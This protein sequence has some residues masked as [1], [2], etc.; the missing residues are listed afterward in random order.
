MQL[1]VNHQ[2]RTKGDVTYMDATADESQAEVFSD[3][4][5]LVTR[6]HAPPGLMFSGEIDTTNAWAVSRS[7]ADAF[8]VHGDAH[9]DL[10]HLIFCDISGI[11]ALVEAAE[12]IGSGRRLLLHGLPHQL[13]TVLRVTG[14][15][16]RPSLVLCNCEVRQT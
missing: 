14:W 12:T 16:D 9:L 10:T 5:L 7:L 15:S 13:Q 1:A 3:R 8:P 11:R 6:T 2:D 4:Q